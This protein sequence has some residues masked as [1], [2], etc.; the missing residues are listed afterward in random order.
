MREIL[1]TLLSSL[2]LP[3][4]VN[5]LYDLRKEKHSKDKKQD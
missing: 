1:L 5:I 4:L 2:I 3:L